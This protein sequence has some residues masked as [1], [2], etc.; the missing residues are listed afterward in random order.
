M[1][2]WLDNLLLH[3]ALLA[4]PRDL[5]RRHGGEM[6]RFLHLQRR[7]ERYRRPWGTLTYWRDV[8]GDALKVGIRRRSAVILKPVTQSFRREINRFRGGTMLTRLWQDL[9]FAARTLAR[10]HTYALVC[11]LTLALGIGVNSAIFSAV[12]SILFKPLPGEDPD[13]LVIIFSLDDHANF[14]H[15]FSNADLRD[16][17]AQSESF[18]YLA[19][20]RMVSLGIAPPGQMSQYVAGE[21]VTTDFFKVVGVEPLLGRVF[22]EQDIDRGNQVAIISHGLWQNQMGGDPDVLGREVILNGASLQVVGVMPE[23]FLGSRFPIR[24]DVWLPLSMHDVANPRQA[25]FDW[26]NSRGHWLETLGRLKPGVSLREA[27]AEF[28][29]IMQ[30]LAEEYPDAN[31]GVRALLVSEQGSRINPQQADNVN[32]FALMLLGLVGFVLLI[33]CAN[34]ANL[35]LSRGAARGR[36]LSVRMAMGAGRKG[37]LQQLLTESLLVAFFGGVLGLVLA[38]AF[39]GLLRNLLPST[40]DFPLKI[41]IQLDWTVIAF[42]AAISLAAGLVFG[43]APAFKASRTDLQSV[44]RGGEPSALGT[45]RLTLPRLLVMAQVMLSVVLLVGAGLFVRSLQEV[46]KFRTGIESD[47]LIFMTLDLSLL[48]YT[49]EQGRAFYQRLRQD[50]KALPG[51]E[52]VSSSMIV[53]LSGANASRSLYLPEGRPD[54]SE[55][56]YIISSNLVGPDFFKTLGTRIVAGRGFTEQDTQDAP[57]VMVVNETLAGQLWPDQN[58]IGKRLFLSMRMERQPVEVVGVAE[59]GRYRT[60]GESPMPF[61]FRPLAQSYEPRRTFWVRTQG[62]PTSLAEALRSTVRSLEPNLPLAGMQTIEQHRG[63]FLLLPRL[64]AILLSAFALLALVLALIGVY[65]VISYAVSR[66]HR[67]IGL[68]MALGAERSQVL[69]LVLRQGLTLALTG[70]V[71]GMFAAMLVSRL[72]AGALYGVEPLDPMTFALTPLLLLAA[73]ALAC[74]LP[75][76]RASRIDPMGVLRYE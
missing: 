26:R 55:D 15:E 14:P 44:L 11:I 68:R 8:L 17:R 33:A 34:V 12:H 27:R 49:P 2:R 38:Y 40:F 5:R 61:F 37:L 51:V 6:Q 58:P 59:D 75:A 67:E 45:R 50:L 66:R 16:F 32:F 46:Q 19:G 63:F 29:G 64:G 7:E 65:G 24:F 20:R 74:F 21:L 48:G 28:A 4:Y 54:G 31:Q 70:L 25:G 22:T 13:R 52:S 56:P 42:T 62:E 41:D 3:M 71:L 73:A 30:R 76:A 53:P 47:N 9:K 72:F 18:Q 36:E 39:A 57:L 1:P 43:I 23:G 60:V 10:N 35:M 69:R